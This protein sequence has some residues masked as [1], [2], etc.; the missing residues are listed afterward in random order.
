MVK[1][2][3]IFLLALVVL[4]TAN[5][6]AA[7][8]DGL[9][10]YYPFN[11]NA[12]DEPIFGIEPWFGSDPQAIIVIGVDDGVLEYLGEVDLD[13]SPY[14]RGGGAPPLDIDGLLFDFYGLSV[15]SYEPAP[16]FEGI[17]SPITVVPEPAT[18]LL[19]GLGGLILR[20]RR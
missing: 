15:S 19:L 4:L 18:V 17:S 2:Q 7:I 3:S 10:S 12:D 11:S 6:H 8:T 9:V 5:L 13:V 20:K 16:S 1:R 14:P